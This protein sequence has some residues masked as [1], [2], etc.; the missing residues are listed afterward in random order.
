MDGLCD[1]WVLNSSFSIEH[2]QRAPQDQCLSEQSKN[3]T[4]QPEEFLSH[5]RGEMWIFLGLD[6]CRRY[7]CSSSLLKPALFSLRYHDCAN[8]DHPEYDLPQAPSPSF[9]YHSHGPL[10]LCVLHLRLCSSH[11]VRYTQLPGGK[12]ETTRAKQ[13]ES[14]TGRSKEPAE[15]DAVRT[16]S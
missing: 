11:G 4:R 10:C 14:Q 5:M 6:A 3:G 1:T 2:C 7:K 12:Q 8:N 15:V 13:Q 9:L 16:S